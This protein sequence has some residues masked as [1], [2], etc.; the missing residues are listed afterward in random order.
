LGLGGLVMSLIRP[1]YVPILYGVL[2]AYWLSLALKRRQILGQEA[3]LAGA[4]CLPAFPYA[5]LVVATF[6][7]NPAM[8]GWAEQNPL[9]TP[10][11]DDLLAGI[12]L[13]LLPAVLGVVQDRWWH[14]DRRL[15]LVAWAAVLPLLLYSPL[16]LQRRLVG[17][18][19]VALA[20]PA[21]HWIDQHALPWLG[22]ARWRTAVFGPLLASAACLLFSYPL[23]FVWGA[24]EYVATRPETL[25]LTADEIAALDW[26]KTRPPGLVVMAAE[27]T[28]RYIPAYSRAIPVL[29]HPVET[30]A[31]EEKRADVSRFF[32]ADTP[33]ADR[34]AILNRY[35]AAV[36]WRGPRERRLGSFDP[37]ILHGYLLGFEQGPIKVWISSEEVHDGW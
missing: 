9:M 27:D 15:L 16:P 3:A 17:G 28:G 32:A 13:F 26:L 1:D 25:F 37:A 2:I 19:Q 4:I 29:G 11:L 36:I 33:A 8:A 35:S 12:G 21:G 20:V 5:L 6:R 30:L 18:V 34:L 10:P 7:T 23:L 31:V 24:V 14:D 22:K